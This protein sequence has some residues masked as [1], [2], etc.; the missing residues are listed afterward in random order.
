MTATVERRPPVSVVELKRAWH[1]VQAG[2]FR[3][4][5]HGRSANDQPH[6]G[7]DRAVVDPQCRRA[8]AAG[9]P[10]CERLR[11]H[12]VCVGIGDRREHRRAGGRVQ[13][14]DIIGVGRREH[15]RTGR[16]SFRV[17]AG[18][19]RRGAAAADERRAGK[20]ARRPATPCGGEDDADRPRC[21]LG[22]RARAQ[23]ANILGGCPGQAGRRPSWWLRVPRSPA[24][25]TSN[26]HWRSLDGIPPVVAVVGPPRKRWPKAV[27]HSAGALTRAADSAG[28]L[29]VVPHDRRLAVAGLDSTPLPTAVLEAAAT[30]LERVDLISKGK[31]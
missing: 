20:R 19:P 9:G 2:Q 6:A 1:A 21:R 13:L 10:V 16:A 17:G 11:C 7:T 25:A 29:L 22:A 31:R 3:Q 15:R 8:G 30:A 18:H 5:V 12:H 14:G 26:V 4:T 27:R 24:C 23:H 28:R